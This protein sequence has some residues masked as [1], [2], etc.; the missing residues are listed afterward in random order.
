[1][2]WADNAVFVDGG[3]AHTLES[4]D[5]TDD[6][7]F[8][9]TF[10]KLLLNT[11]R[12]ADRDMGAGGD[13]TNTHTHTHHDIYTGLQSCVSVDETASFRLSR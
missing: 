6:H 13:H 3:E 7:T 4:S 10:A 5:L 2:L 8:Y 11:D 9:H 12:W 1:M